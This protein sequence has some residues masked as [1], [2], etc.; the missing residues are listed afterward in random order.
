MNPLIVDIVLKVTLVLGV[1]PLAARLLS[2]RSAAARHQIWAVALAA[3][4]LMPVLATVAPQWTIAVLPA[5]AAPPALAPTPEMTRTTFADPVFEPVPALT[6]SLGSLPQPPDAS[7]STLSATTTIWIAGVLLVLARLACGTARVWWIARRA[8]QAAVWAPLGRR[9]ARSLGIDRRVAFLRGD[10]D[11]MPM[12]WGL[13]RA[14]VLLPAEADDWPIERQRVVLLH[15][16]AHVRRRD[17][18]TQ[19]LAHLACAAYWFNPLVWL[20]AR[21]LRAERERACDD[22]VLAVGTRASD[23]ADH[24][25]D[26]ARSLRS[27]AWPTWSAVTMAHRSQLE[28]RLMAILNP[29]L[30]RRSP[31]R[32]S[33]AVFAIVAMVSIVS[34]AGVRA[35]AKTAEAEEQ[36]R[37]SAL[38]SPAPTPTPA[39]APA[40]APMPS[41]SPTPAPAP[42]PRAPRAAVMPTPMPPAVQTP[43]PTPVPPAPPLA[44]ARIVAPVI[45]GPFPDIDVNVDVDVDQIR[46]AF[47]TLQAQSQK[48]RGAA[49]DPKITAALTAALRDEDEG[50]RKQAL[51]TLV[52]MRAPLPADVIASMLKDKSPDVR[53]HAVFALGQQ[54]DPKN[55]SLLADALKDASADVRKQAAF[56][57]G[58]LRDARAVDPLIAALKDGDPDVRKQAAFSLGQIRDARAVDALIAALKDPNADVRQ[59]AVFALGQIR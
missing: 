46:D 16:L 9:L 34:L 12:A 47:V 23:Y 22:L 36:G 37:P 53:N 42:A 15:E 6:P 7:V 33:V 40:P 8:T 52:R 41:Q 54:R 26:I 55:V 56:A 31:T 25:L 5:P 38:A 49:A 24:L 30:P 43:T 19:M 51:N 1:A 18:L 2:R 57:L 29:A 4:L 10:E 48:G 45:T 20:A 39:P 14:H 13:V 17:S 58:Q 32:R 11:A 44:Q 50:V 59:Q 35:V 28:G 3:S 27:G 21:R